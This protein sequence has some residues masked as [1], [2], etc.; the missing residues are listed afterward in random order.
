[1]R[2]VDPYRAFR[3]K[4]ELNGVQI[5]GFSDVTGLEV[6]TEVEEYREGGVNG[7]VHKIA[8]E[9]RYPNLVL[10]RGIT[11]STD[12]WLWH[13]EVVRGNVQRKTV[14]VILEDVQGRE[15]WRWVFYEAFPIKWSGSELNATG[16]TVVVESIE[17]VHHGMM[18]DR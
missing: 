3:F 16:N 6:S 8:K 12:L 9:S 4:V 11:D 18:K 7:Y 14:S 15:K 2:P 1:M 17:L 5:G 13:Q 10:K